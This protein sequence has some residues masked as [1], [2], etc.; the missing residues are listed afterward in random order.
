MFCTKCD[1]RLSLLMTSI[2]RCGLL[3][4]ILFIMVC[5]KFFSGMILCLISPSVAWRVNFNINVTSFESNIRSV[6][7]FVDLA[8]R[9]PFSKPPRVLFISSIGVF[10][11]NWKQS[12]ITNLCWYIFLRL[13]RKQ[14]CARNASCSTRQRGWY[15]LCGVKMGL[16]ANITQSVA[17]NST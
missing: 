16:R 10:Q 13:P 11:S 7:N 1:Y 15:W 17:A 2:C 5:S 4:L 9:S 12:F 6:R 8:L 14:V 3:S